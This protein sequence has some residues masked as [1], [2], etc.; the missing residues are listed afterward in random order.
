MLSVKGGRAP[1]IGDIW[2]FDHPHSDRRMVK[3]IV[4]MGGDTVQMK[5][6]R[7]VINGKEIGRKWVRGLTYSDEG[8]PT[9]AEEYLEQLPGEARPHL[10]HEFSDS[11]SLDET[12]IFKVP[13]GHLFFMGDNRDNSEDSRAPSGHRGLAAS[14]PE[15]WP[16]RGFSPSFDPSN[17]A[18]GFVPVENLI[19]R[20]ATVFYSFHSCSPARVSE[21]CLTPK[22]G[23]HL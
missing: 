7:L 2:V 22:I 14:V 3:R 17:D 12:P 4:A 16:N 19:A 20:V 18:I 9:S 5:H 11:D 23:E 13:T 21:E 10:I 15:L 8:R 1:R 6:G